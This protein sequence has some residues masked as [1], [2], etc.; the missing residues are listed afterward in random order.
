MVVS[1]RGATE[2]GQG[3]GWREQRGRPEGWI[4]NSIA[5]DQLIAGWLTL[6]GSLYL[7]CV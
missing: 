5:F 7:S 1:S 6:R 3:S 4:T 2:N